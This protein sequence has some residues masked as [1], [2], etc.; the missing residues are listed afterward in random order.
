MKLGRIFSFSKVIRIFSSFKS[1]KNTYI[2][3]P[4]FLKKRGVYGEDKL[5]AGMD[6]PAFRVEIVKASKKN[7]KICFRNRE[8]KSLIYEP[9]L[10]NPERLPHRFVCQA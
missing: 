8:G 10:E 9:F 4:Y 1:E 6:N 2:S 5:L 7:E 3:V